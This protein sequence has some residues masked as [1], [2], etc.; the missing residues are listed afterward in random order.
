M[1]A[2]TILGLGTL[3]GKTRH[4]DF[5]DKQIAL[6]VVLHQRFHTPQYALHMPVRDDHRL[7]GCEENVVFGCLDRSGNFAYRM[8]GLDHISDGPVALYQGFCFR[9]LQTG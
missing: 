4:R 9:V 8:E 2:W 1:P 6:S 3:P 5:S 7:T